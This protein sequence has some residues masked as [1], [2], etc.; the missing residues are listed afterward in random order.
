MSLRGPGPQLRLRGA[1]REQPFPGTQTRAGGASWVWRP[2]T[3]R[4]M[5]RPVPGCS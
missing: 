4:Q 1:G 2:G 5:M 3:W